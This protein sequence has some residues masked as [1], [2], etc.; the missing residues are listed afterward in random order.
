M[1][2]ILSSAQMQQCDANTMERF[3]M[4]SAVL[5]ERAALSAVSEI[6]RQYPDPSARILLVCGTGNNGGDGLA[7]ARLLYLKEYQIQIFFPGKEERCSVEAA[8]QLSIVRAYGIAV[9]DRFPTE[10]YDVIVDALFGIGLSRDVGGVYRDVVAWM[11]EQSGWKMAVDIASGIS[12]DDGRVMGI[13]FQADFTATFGFAK[14]GQLLYPGA[15]CT[16]RLAIEDIGIDEN[17]LLGENPEICLPETEDLSL[18]PKRRDDSNKGTYGKLLIFAGSRNMAGAAAF[19]A[20][21]ACRAGSGLVRVVTDSSNREIIQTLVPEAILATYDAGTDMQAFVKDQIRWA[22]AVVLGP[23]IGQSAQAE[24]M[25]RC[26]LAEVRVPCL[27]DADGLNILSDHPD[28]LTGTQAALVLTPH[29]GEMSRLCRTSVTEIKNKLLQTAGDFAARCGV[30]VVLKD[31]RTVT[32][33]PDGR[34]YIN[35]TGNHGMATAG[36]GDVLTGI[37]GALL[38]QSVPAERAAFLG[39]MI[40]GMAGDAAAGKVGKTSLTATDLIEGICDVLKR[41][42]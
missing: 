26:V 31:A 4:P 2:Y 19:S 18:L 5:M 8:R 28:W 15:A 34:F 38:G 16:G 42:K 7:M 1:K 13:A 10:K 24:K 12:A 17:S 6:E 27:V 23:G 25:A 41:Q 39:V 40:H 30:T 11:N 29:P 35:T 37:I 32:A 22:D 14:I 20:G 36:S 3:H 21:A 33:L 9:T